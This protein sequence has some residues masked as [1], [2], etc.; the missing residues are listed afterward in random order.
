MVIGQ[1]NSNSNTSLF[2]V[3]NGTSDGARSNAFRVG[4]NGTSFQ[5]KCNTEGAD[6][7][8]YF[9]WA[10][11]NP[12]NEDRVGY[13]VSFDQNDTIKIGGTDDLLGVVSATASIVANSYEDSWSEKYKKD[14]YGRIQYE[15][16]ANAYGELYQ[17]PILNEKYNPDLP[18]IPRS[19][20]PEWAVIGMLGRLI[21]RDDGSCIPGKY[22]TSNEDGIATASSVGY[23]VLKR[24]DES[25]IQILFK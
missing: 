4:T 7:A 15:D 22:C 19:Q 6:Y 14:I 21:V 2:I 12:H 8:E 20:R 10:D 13:F 24:L 1:Y 3:G 9:E 17:K 11:K 18:Y 23:R 16:Y 5:S 25:H